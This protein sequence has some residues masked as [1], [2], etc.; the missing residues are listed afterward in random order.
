MRVTDDALVFAARLL[1]LELSSEKR[2]RLL[3]AYLELKT[4][5]EV[6]PAL[7]TLKAAGVD[8]AL[9]SN[10][11]PRMLNRCIEAAGIEGI[12]EHVLSTDAA[13]TYKPDPRA[14]QLGIDALKLPR[15]QIL[16]VAFAGWDAAG[17]K[18]FGFP[19]YWVNR[20]GLPPEE[21]GVLPDAV[22]SSLT[23]LIEHVD[24]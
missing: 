3:S 6:I 1:A 5:P 8:L 21:L 15:E 7:T 12:I 11:T 18:S 17:A 22:G 19:T 24:S 10:F 20:L 13:Q 9:L 2:E 16:F 23:D 4:W 14:Y